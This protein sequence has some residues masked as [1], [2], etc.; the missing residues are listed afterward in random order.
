MTQRGEHWHRA[1]KAHRL[2]CA[3]ETVLLAGHIDREAWE[4]HLDAVEPEW[5]RRL[6]KA[7]NNNL[8]QD[9]PHN[10]RINEPSDATI[11]MAR[12]IVHARLQDQWL[13]PLDAGYR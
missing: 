12:A 6:A 3:A 10:G 9:D 8:S 1:L 4:G 7:W 2:A 13:N 5:W 11:E